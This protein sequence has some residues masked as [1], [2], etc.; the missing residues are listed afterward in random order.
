[1]APERKTPPCRLRAV[2]T[3]VLVVL[4]AAK[5]SSDPC[6]YSLSPGSVALPSSGG[7]GLV[8][9]TAPAGCP[10]QPTAT[11]PWISTMGSG[12]GNGSVGYWVGANGAGPRSGSIG[13]GGQTFTITQAAAA[14]T[15]GVSPTSAAVPS[16]GAFGTFTV[17]TG[18]WCSWMAASQVP[19]ITTMGGGQG[20]AV[21]GYTVLVNPTGLARSG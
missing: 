4:G 8:T 7:N 2:F 14:C 19:W 17:T 16:A 21:V 10:W 5:A 13:V 1:M 20:S 3:A 12:T 15:Y 6:T 9:V 18:G 11:A